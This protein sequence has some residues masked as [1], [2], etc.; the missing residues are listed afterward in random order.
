MPKDPNKERECCKKCN[1]GIEVQGESCFNGGCPCHQSKEEKCDHS[2]TNAI[3]GNCL[4]C[5]VNIFQEL[6]YGGHQS[7]EDPRCGCGQLFSKHGTGSTGRCTGS[8]NI[9]GAA[10]TSLNGKFEE[11]N[12][13]QGKERTCCGECGLPNMHNVEH[14]HDLAGIEK[15]LRIPTPLES[16][17]EEEVGQMA[18]WQKELMDYFQFDGVTY[19][20]HRHWRK[21]IK[22]D[23]VRQFIKNVL[24]RELSLSQKKV[25][26]EVRQKIEKLEYFEVE[27]SGNFGV[28]VDDILSIL[29]QTNGTE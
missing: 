21:D 12:Y 18:N 13:L 6:P 9:G 27:N 25:Y 26:E 1:L 7:K 23:L 20:G 24:K 22:Y 19:K 4:I 14:K 15:R 3:S 29:S 5:G 8:R 10:G 11:V 2:R 28:M 17:W 16:S